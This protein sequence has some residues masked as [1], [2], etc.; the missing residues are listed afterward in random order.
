MF[1]GIEEVMA[2]VHNRARSSAKKVKVI[3]CQGETVP[4]EIPAVL[5][6]YTLAC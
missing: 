6:V 3:G 5:A 2:D 1:A 4:T